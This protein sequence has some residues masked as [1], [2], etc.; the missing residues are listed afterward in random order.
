M[1]LWLDDVRPAPDGWV[2]VRSVNEA[3]TEVQMVRQLGEGW[4]DASLDHDL[5]DYALDGGDG[6]KFVLWMAEYGVWPD[7]K[8]TVH[9]M[10][11]VG[12]GRMLAD[13]DRY[14]SQ[15]LV[16]EVARLDTGEYT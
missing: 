7:N 9:S 13:I 5:G 4:E 16:D 10:N 8:P 1:K 11:P 2:H 3:I 15:A 14:W 12:R 6:Y